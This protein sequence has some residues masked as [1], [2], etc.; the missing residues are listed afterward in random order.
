[1]LIMSFYEFKNVNCIA[2]S[3]QWLTERQRQRVSGSEATT[4]RCMDLK[5]ERDGMRVESLN[6]ESM[7]DVFINVREK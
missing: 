7:I 5:K 6:G 1:M 4:N 2:E 3:G